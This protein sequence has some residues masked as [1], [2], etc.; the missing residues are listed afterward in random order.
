MFPVVDII[1]GVS[2]TD[3]AASSVSGIELADADKESSPRRHDPVWGRAA[4]NPL[5]Y[6]VASNGGVAGVL[7]VRVREAGLPRIV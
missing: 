5:R 7:V 4:F 1:F 2:T 6:G 3:G